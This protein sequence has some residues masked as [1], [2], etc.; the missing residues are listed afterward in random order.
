MVRDGA[1]G[2][3]AATH[4]EEGMSPALSPIRADGERPPNSNVTKAKASISKR[5]CEG[6][7]REGIAVSE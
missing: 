4:V 5:I 3:F 1:K 2:C 6:E 7:E